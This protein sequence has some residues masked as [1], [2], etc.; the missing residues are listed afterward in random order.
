MT[1]TP[2][3]KAKRTKSK[4][5]TSLKIKQALTVENIQNQNLTKL[6]LSGAFLEAFGKPQNKG[7]WFVWGSSGSGKSVF[8]MALAKEL[9]KTQKVFYNLLEE[10]TDDADYVERT[11]LLQM[12]EVSHNFLTGTYTYEEL[13][14]YL[15]KRNSPDVV[16]IDSITYFTKSFDQY[17][18]LKRKYK[19]KTIIISGHAEGKNPRTEFEKSIMYDAKMK[20]FVSGYLALCKGRTIGPNGG[21]FIIWDEGYEK[22][23]GSKED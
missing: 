23:R 21:R 6:K 18:E 10:E 5:S 17:M 7:V 4:E 12:R 20:I 1:Q 11:K 3:R 14:V 13:D 15:S 22:I 19:N 9:A 2:L 16:F 8:L